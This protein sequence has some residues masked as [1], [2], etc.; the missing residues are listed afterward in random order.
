MI[1]AGSVQ[2]VNL[3]NIKIFAVLHCQVVGDILDHFHTECR[4]RKEI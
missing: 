1:H 4:K 3:Q 2:F